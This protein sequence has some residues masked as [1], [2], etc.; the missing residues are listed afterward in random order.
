[1]ARKEKKYHFIYKTTNLLTGRYYIGMHSTDNLEDGYMGSGKRLRRS[2]NKYG[3]ENHK[4]EILEFV[5][6]RE[7]L[8]KKE[9]EIVSLNEIAKKQCM[10]LM[11]GGRGG[12]I[13]DKQQKKRAIAA[14]KALVKKLKTDKEFNDN[15]RKKITE[16]VIKSYEKGR[17]INLPLFTGKKHT[18][19]TKEKMRKSKLGYG[20]GENNT[21]F[22]TCWITNGIINKKIKKEEFEHFSNKGW[23]KGR[24]L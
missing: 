23:K 21:Q 6:S 2:L 17:K 1:M 7:E 10:N 5:S 20:L 19:K 13:S 9:K 16:G 18:K 15:F 24:K 14:N 12:F 11:A 22:G 8:I 3:K 4:V